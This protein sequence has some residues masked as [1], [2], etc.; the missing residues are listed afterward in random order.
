M[1]H[2]HHEPEH[3]SG[4]GHAPSNRVPSEPR[5]AEVRQLSAGVDS[6]YWSASAVIAPELMAD[7]KAARDAVDR[8][9][10][11]PWGEVLGFLLTVGAHGAGRYPVVLNCAEFRLQLTDSKH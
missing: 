5:A 9:S 3:P 4:G 6:L 2:A 7:V 8:S 10:P 1:S 11:E